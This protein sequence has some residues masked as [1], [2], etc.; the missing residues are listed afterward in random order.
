MHLAI[1]LII[2]FYGCKFSRDNFITF[3]IQVFCLYQISSFHQQYQTAN[4]DI[5]LIHIVC[6]TIKISLKYV[7]TT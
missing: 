2:N 4:F 6:S 5:S 3:G 1:K 7:L